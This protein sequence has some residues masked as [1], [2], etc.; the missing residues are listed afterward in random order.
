MAAASVS[1]DGKYGVAVNFSRI[2]DFRKG[3][4]YPGFEDE[5]ANEK[6][7]KEDG[8]FLIDMETGKSK[9]IISL[10]QLASVSGF[11]EEDKLLINHITFSTG[12]DKFNM[13][14]RSFPREGGTWLTTLVVGDIYGNLKVLLKKDYISHYWW[15][16]NEEII[17]H[18]TTPNGEHTLC[19]IFMDGKIVKT[20]KADNEYGELNFSLKGKDIHCS[21]NPDKKYIM[22]D[23]YPREKI[24]Y[25]P[26][27]AVSTKTGECR[28]ILEVYSEPLENDDSDIRCDLHMRFTRDGKYITFDTIHNDKRQIAK[29]AY[30]D[31]N[32]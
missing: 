14:V 16:S 21:L 28:K 1:P 8:V 18:T 5:F 31:Y 17:A 24:D 2:F 12:S 11:D 7:P 29:F 26:I 3:Y 20:Q 15:A 27:L 13:L 9:L 19:S 4:G 22:G 23:G 25:R 10:E 32:F 6:C 30:K